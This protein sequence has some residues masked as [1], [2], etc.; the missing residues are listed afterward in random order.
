MYIKK[1]KENLKQQMKT[2][3]NVTVWGADR[4]E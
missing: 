3:S 2:F 4:S 1:A